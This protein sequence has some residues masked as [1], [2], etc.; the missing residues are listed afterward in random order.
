MPRGRSGQNAA[1]NTVARDD[2]F[3]EDVDDPAA[4]WQREAGIRRPASGRTM[5]PPL[6]FAVRDEADG[7]RA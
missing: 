4:T 3:E 7:D 6:A 5:P 2:G 1:P